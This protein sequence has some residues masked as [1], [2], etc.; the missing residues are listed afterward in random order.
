MHEEY[1]ESISSFG[2]VLFSH[3]QKSFCFPSW[4]LSS[5][6][7]YYGFICVY[8]YIGIYVSH[9]LIYTNYFIKEKSL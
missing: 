4:M 6:V 7:F 1:A 3:T 9:K 5:W 2:K 8:K